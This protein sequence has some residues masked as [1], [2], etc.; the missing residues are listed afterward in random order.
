MSGAW[1]FALRI[2][3]FCRR[4]LY[5]SH[6]M[7]VLRFKNRP[8]KRMRQAPGGIL[9]TFLNTVP[10]QPGEQQLVSQAEWDRFGKKFYDSAVKTREELRRTAQRRPAA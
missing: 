9:L 10:G 8:V 2:T 4:L 7:V 6:L 1:A 5:E 3:Y